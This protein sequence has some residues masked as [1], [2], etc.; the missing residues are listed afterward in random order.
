MEA[1]CIE[2]ISLVEDSQIHQALGVFK[3]SVC[4]S[5]GRLIQNM[6]PLPHAGKFHSAGS[7]AREQLLGAAKKH[8]ACRSCG[9]SSRN[10]IVNLVPSKV[11]PAAGPDCTLPSNPGMSRAWLSLHACFCCLK[12]VCGSLER[13]NITICWETA[14]KESACPIALGW[15]HSMF[16]WTCGLFLPVACQKLAPWEREEGGGRRETLQHSC[17]MSL[18]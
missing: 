15:W 4:L 3:C 17:R 13:E 8:P 1:A 5:H 10:G 9:G 16:V 14:A 11:H 12:V 2:E 18:G 6:E 7:T